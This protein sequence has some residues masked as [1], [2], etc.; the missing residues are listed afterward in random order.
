MAQ[1]GT[2]RL[3]TVV[4]VQ[5]ATLSWLREQ[6]A[7]GRLKPGDQVRQEV[8]AREFGVSVPPM[9]EALKTLE[10]EGQL[11]Y[12][13]HRGYFV[14]SMS[15]EEL[16]ETYRIRQLLETEAITRSVP[17]LGAEEVARMREAAQVMEHSHGTA[18]VRAIAEANR[19]FHFTLFDAAAMPRM[20]D[21][22]RVLWG[23]TDRYR[24]RYF[25]T[26]EHRRRV[27]REHRQIL[28]AAGQGDAAL[29]AELSH[30]H[31]TH[32][33]DA[34]ARALEDSTDRSAACG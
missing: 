2:P 17:L 12:H 24:A 22:I 14:A 1:D 5:H 25:S 18:D 15:Y 19:V 11:V 30:Q 33:L 27:N 10:A 16:A 3:R 6:L 9:R 21:M 7:T 29:V 8:L 13:P 31:R 4:T 26:A 28:A 32:S 23:S 20:A 34:L